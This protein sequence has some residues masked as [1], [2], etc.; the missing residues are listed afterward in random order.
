MHSCSVPT[1]GQRTPPPRKHGATS[2]A[3]GVSTAKLEFQT[4][5]FPRAAELPVS[6]QRLPTECYRKA[7]LVVRI[8]S[9]ASETFR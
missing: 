6:P 2:G 1:R 5:V 9:A 3:N 4:D 8:R 7:S